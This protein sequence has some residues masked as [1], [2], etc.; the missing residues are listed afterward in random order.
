[1]IVVKESVIG[2][3][4]ESGFMNGIGKEERGKIRL[5]MWIDFMIGIRII[6]KV[7]GILIFKWSKIIGS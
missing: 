1:M 7:V 3:E 5:I 6:G 4:V 2:I